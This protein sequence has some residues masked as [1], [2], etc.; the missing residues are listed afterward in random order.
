MKINVTVD[1]DDFFN[2]DETSFNE[3]IISSLN[4]QI[5]REIWYNFR[6]LALDEFK[7]KIEEQFNQEKNNE[8]ERIIS[9]I[10][11]EKR[12]KTK[13]TKDG[14]E[15][16][17]LFEYIEDKLSSAY[18]SETSSA[19]KI[20][21]SKIASKDDEIKKSIINSAEKLSNDLKNRYD[22]LFASQI[23]AKLNENGMLKE[24]VAKILLGQ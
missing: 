2:E 7:A 12:I 14:V 15:T 3:Q 18:F 17:T 23:V 1:L 8:L 11:S 6:T 19:E 20:L 16:V 5:M 13:L 4:H 10:F 9:K 21:E 24:D 22:L